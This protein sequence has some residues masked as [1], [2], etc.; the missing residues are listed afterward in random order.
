MT[1]GIWTKWIIGAA[2]LLL[3]VAAGC[4]WYY[5]H[6]TAADKQA[7]EQTEKLLQEW[8]ADK[9]KPPAETETTHTPAESTQNTAEKPTHKIGEGTTE[10]NTDKPTDIPSLTYSQG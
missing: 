9:A 7:A 10:T 2:C 6:T 5:Q 1:R 4:F 8:E 3:I